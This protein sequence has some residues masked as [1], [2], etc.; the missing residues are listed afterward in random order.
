MT[1]L[2]LLKSLSCICFSL[3]Y[4]PLPSSLSWAL[5]ALGLDSSL[6]WV[7]YYWPLTNL[8]FLWEKQSTWRMWL[9]SISCALLFVSSPAP[10]WAWAPVKVWLCI[11]FP[12]EL[13]WPSSYLFH[14][15]LLVTTQDPTLLCAVRYQDNKTL[16]S[17]GNRIWDCAKWAYALFVVQLQ[18]LYLWM[19]VCVVAL[20]IFST[21]N[22]KWFNFIMNTNYQ[23]SHKG[24]II[25]IDLLLIN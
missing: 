18:A 25:S 5:L 14:H 19:Q 15:H 16:P 21:L 24:E 13:L 3:P 11:L 20:F 17:Q 2:S 10:Q 8:S 7:Y 23:E 9:V 22:V 4:L 12:L 1:I 6:S